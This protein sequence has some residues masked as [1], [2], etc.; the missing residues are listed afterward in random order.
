MTGAERV[1]QVL[2]AHGITREAI[3]HRANSIASHRG[4]KPVCDLAALTHSSVTV[5][6]MLELMAEAIARVR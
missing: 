3:L 6:S 1:R 2:D 4:R 5:A